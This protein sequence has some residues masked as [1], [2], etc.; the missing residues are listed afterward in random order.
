LI[1]PVW[2]GDGA[3]LAACWLDAGAYYAGINPEL[4]QIPESPGL[5]EWMEPGNASASPDRC[6]FVAE[7]EG[8][9]VGFINA[10]LHQ[11]R[12]DA[13][14][15]FVRDV[16]R[17]RLEIDALVVKQAYWR[18]GVGTQLMRAAEQWGRSQGAEIALLDTYVCSEVSVPFYEWTMGYSRR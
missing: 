17:A 16:G 15:P 8:T 1:R 11:P 9:V 10:S 2:P 7:L 12:A 18:R 6:A 3:G 5:D 13:A 14:R 4:F